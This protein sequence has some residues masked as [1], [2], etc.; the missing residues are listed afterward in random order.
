MENPF[1]TGPTHRSHP[2]QRVRILRREGD[3]L[4]LNGNV[5]VD[6]ERHAGRFVADLPDV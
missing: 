1:S 4:D 5:V 6:I 2:P 3:S